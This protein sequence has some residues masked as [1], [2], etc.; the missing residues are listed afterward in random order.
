[1]GIFG[2]H[3]GSWF[4]LP[5]FGV[6]EGISNLFGGQRTS[7]G[8]SNLFGPPSTQTPPPDNRSWTQNSDLQAWEKANQP[9]PKT[10]PQPSQQN[11][12]SNTSSSENF[13]DFYQG[14]PNSEAFA[15]YTQVFNR[16]INRL[17][18]ARGFGSSS[19]NQPQQPDMSAQID[20]IYNP[21]YAS[22]QNQENFLT[23][24]Q[25]PNA[26]SKIKTSAQELES[27]LQ[28]NKLES[29]RTIDLQKSDITQNRESALASA[30]RAKNA[31]TRNTQALYGG[32]SSTGGAINE[33]SN[34]EVLR[35]QGGIEQAFTRS[36]QTI[37]DFQSKSVDWVQRESSRI[38]ASAEQQKRD[39]ADQFSQQ[40]MQ[41]NNARDQ[42]ESAKAT[43]KYNLL[44]EAQAAA[45]AVVQ[46]KKD[47]DMQLQGWFQQQQFLI[48]NGI[49]DLKQ[50]YSNIGS[51]SQF[52]ADK[53]TMGRT[54][55]PT[56]ATTPAKKQ[57]TTPNYL[58][59]RQ[60]EFQNL[61]NPFA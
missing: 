50:Q 2:S 49:S 36:F 30:I 12:P 28:A 56:S 21:T 9:T 25:L 43:A 13:M 52:Q 22:L 3:Q 34:Q 23:N 35:T 37:L 55:T 53:T 33:L 51:S 8:G 1:M 24:T 19:N 18:Q 16:D 42:V 27:A 60:D 10:Q 39:I 58:G 7:Q 41:I 4:G 61:I 40:I 47:Y 59:Q 5:D 45:Q 20:A 14:W 26:L 46:S 44:A 17:K 11:T 29:Q 31:L 32:G 38:A 48:N 57:V 54:Y 15:D 6:S